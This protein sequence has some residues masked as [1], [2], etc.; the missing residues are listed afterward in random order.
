MYGALPNTGLNLSTPIYL[1]A[2]LAMLAICGAVAIRERFA[3][4]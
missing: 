2:G 3:R 1:I 4:G